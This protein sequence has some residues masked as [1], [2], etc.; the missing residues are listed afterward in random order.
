MSVRKKK[1]AMSEAELEKLLGELP[2][3]TWDEIQRLRSD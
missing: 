2:P 1:Q 3:P